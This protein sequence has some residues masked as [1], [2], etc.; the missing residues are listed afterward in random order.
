M[1][2]IYCKSEIPEYDYDYIGD[3]VFPKAFGC[4]ENWTLTCVC[5]QCNVRFGGTIDRYLASDSREGVWRLEKLGSKSGKEVRQKRIEILVSKEGVP[6]EIGGTHVWMDFKNKSQIVKKPQIV[7]Q[8]ESGT[9]E[10]F[11]VADLVHEVET[12]KRESI[13]RLLSLQNT[14][15]QC[16]IL[17]DT[18]IEFNETLS[19]LRHIGIQFQVEVERKYLIEAD[20]KYDI[21]ATIDFEILRAI[22]KIG[23]NYFAYTC[24][25]DEAL[26]GKYDNLRSFI[27]G[28]ETYD[29]ISDCPVVP[30][31]GNIFVGKEGQ[32]SYIDKH[33]VTIEEREGNILGT[34]VLGNTVNMFYEIM[35]GAAEEYDLVGRGTVFSTDDSG[36]IELRKILQKEKWLWAEVKLRSDW[37]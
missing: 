3:H 19:V 16:Y 21:Y 18:E 31:G 33:V 7:V 6:S 25:C 34:V 10:I 12:G 15:C 13:D 32:K 26:K 1:R 17:Q 37:P 28:T 35:F 22:G 5:Q 9:K 23:M 14:G 36:L 11:A 27:A 4:P 20:P 29:R 30:V 8:Q 2:C 24:G